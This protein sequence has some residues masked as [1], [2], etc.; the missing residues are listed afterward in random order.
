MNNTPIENNT[1]FYKSLL[2]QVNSDHTI[3]VTVLLSIVVILLGATWWW[4][5]LGADKRIKSEVNKQ[6]SKQ[7]Q[8]YN[9]IFTDQVGEQVKLQINAFEQDLLMVEGSAIRS[10][11]LQAKRDKHYKH[12]IYWFTKHLEI[13]LKLDRK[14]EQEIRNN[15]NWI[16]TEIE[17]LKKQDEAT[18]A[19]NLLIY[20]KE[21]IINIVSQL[22]DIIAIEKRKILAF[23]EDR[24]EVED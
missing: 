6:I 21:Y 3:F 24:N 18:N 1:D 4:N 16:I 22:S 19:T 20:K 17:L 12:S 7:L 11:A 2:E 15:V 23:I 9:K 13:Y 10:I 14:Y 5:F 8:K